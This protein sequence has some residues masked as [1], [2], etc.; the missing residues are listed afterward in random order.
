MPDWRLGEKNLFHF[1]CKCPVLKI[2]TH[3]L[4]NNIICGLQK[5]KDF[6]THMA[7]KIFFGLFQNPTGVWLNLTFAFSICYWWNIFKSQTVHWINVIQSCARKHIYVEIHS[8]VQFKKFFH[9][10]LLSTL[11][12]YWK[13]EIY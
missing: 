13:L 3:P 9:L 6:I 5:L 11:L 2:T 12:V 1:Y 10:L 8:G 7:S 4:A